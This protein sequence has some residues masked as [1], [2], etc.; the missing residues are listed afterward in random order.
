M[1]DAVSWVADK[2]DKQIHK[3]VTFLAYLTRFW[4]EVKKAIADECEKS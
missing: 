1:E 4:E 3:P 2:P